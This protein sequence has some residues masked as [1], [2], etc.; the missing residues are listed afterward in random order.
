MTENV[1]PIPG[2]PDFPWEPP[3]AGSELEHL[4]GML[5]RLRWTFRWKA[6]GLD[7][8]GLSKRLGPSALTL[9]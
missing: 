1:D 6:S 2:D 4:I 7:S 5:D 9:G 8:D 3:L